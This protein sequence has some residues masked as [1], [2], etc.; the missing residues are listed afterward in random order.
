MPT[1]TYILDLHLFFLTSCFYVNCLWIATTAS[2]HLGFPGGA[3]GKDPAC[4]CRRWK[5]CAFIPWVGKVPWKSTWQPT[6]VFLPGESPRTE[7]PGGS[8]SMESQRVGHN[9]S[10]LARLHTHLLVKKMVPLQNHQLSFLLD[11]RIYI[12]TYLKNWLTWL[13]RLGSPKD[14]YSKGLRPRRGSGI[15]SS[16]SLRAKGDWCPSSKTGR[17]IMNSS[18][19]RFY[20]GLRWTEWTSLK[21]GVQSALL[22]LQIQKL[23]SSRNTF[24]DTPRIMFNQVSG[25]RGTVKLTC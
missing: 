13:W 1:T 2:T 25:P 4:Q 16:P 15:S 22:S 23:I 8:Q 11:I 10:N 7:E 14:L 5:R 9:W 3:S 17:K 24:T 21:F 20:L 19:F 18:L 12:Y 6:P